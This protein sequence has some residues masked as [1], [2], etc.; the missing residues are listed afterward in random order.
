MVWTKKLNVQNYINDI[1]LNMCCF[2]NNP[3]VIE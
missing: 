2:F 3:H 1:P